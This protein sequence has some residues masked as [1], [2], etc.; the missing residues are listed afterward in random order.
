MPVQKIK[1]DKDVYYFIWKNF[2]P[3]EMDYLLEKYE[4][5][6]NW[7]FL[8]LTAISS[9]SYELSRGLI[10]CFGEPWASIVKSSILI[11]VFVSSKSHCMQTFDMEAL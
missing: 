8:I 11:S 5:W 4:E 10:V 3:R 2:S 1:M 7:K 9:F 6:K